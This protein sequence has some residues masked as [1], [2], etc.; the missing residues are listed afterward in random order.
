MRGIF[1]STTSWSAGR[2]GLG[3]LSALVLAGVI[4][5][6]QPKETVAPSASDDPVVLPETVVQGVRPAYEPNRGAGSIFGGFDGARNAPGSGAL[7][8]LEILRSQSYD[9]PGRVLGQVPGVYVREEDGFGNFPNISLRGVDMARSAKVTIMEDGILAAPAPYSAPSAYYFPTIGRMYAV[10]VFKGSSQVQFGPHSTGGA[11]NFLSTPIPDRQ[12]SYM[13]TL[14]GTNNEM[15]VHAWTGNTWF[16]ESGE[17][18]GYLLEGYFRETDGFKTIDQADNFPV[19]NATDT[20]FITREPMV[21]VFWEPNT[22]SYQRFE[23]KW[24]YT[25]MN[26]NEG[27]VGLTEDDF[28]LD[29]LRRYSGTR[30]DHMA[31]TAARSYLRHTLG[32]PEVDWFTFTQTV[33]YTKFNRDW[34]KLARVLDGS[35][36]YSLPAILGDPFTNSIGYG[37]LTGQQAGTLRLRHN[38]R[39]YSAYGYDAVAMMAVEG[40]KADHDISVGFRYHRDRVRRFQRDDDYLLS[41]NGAV[42]SITEGSPGAAGDRRQVTKAIAVYL[43]DRMDFG[44]LAVT[45]GIRFESLDGRYQRF[46]GELKSVFD[47]RDSMTMVSGG[48]GM[49]YDL[50][51]DVQLLAGFHRGFSPPSPSKITAG[52]R[53]EESLASELGVRLKDDEQHWAAQLIGFYT[54]FNDLIVLDNVGS[55][56]E[57]ENDEQVGEV[58]ATGIEAMLEFDMGKRRGWKFSSPWFISMTYTDAKLLSDTLS[59]DAGSIFADGLAGAHMPYIPEFTMMVGIGAH[60]EKMGIDLT[61]IYADQ[62]FSTASNEVFSGGPDADIRFGT[63]DDYFLWDLSAY[64]QLNDN[65]RIFGGVQNLFDRRYVT[66][67]HPFGPRTGAPLF[68]YVGVEATF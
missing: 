32:D 57:E 44:R 68:G 40:E 38:N 17:R 19:Q 39:T 26:V 49:T 59:H 35:T 27:Y 36:T 3:L 61:G 23:A 15:R 34:F 25:A 53:E 28:A 65:W 48:V 52:M 51:D 64:R 54:H 16:T 14:F 31:N 42:E 63:A 4:S 2:T 43:Q 20:G 56:A 11:I 18:V 30:F 62:T 58:Y 47:R 41:A 7:L 29:P 67:R 22:L 33:Y 66:T 50:A 6:Q 13:R 10:E 12:A 9:N 46:P 24:G 5:A 55:G 45:P 37:I 21:K 1:R 8:D 60:F